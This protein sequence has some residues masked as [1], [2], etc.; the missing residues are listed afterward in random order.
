MSPVPTSLAEWLEYIERQHPKA[1]ALGLDRVARVR[2][3]LG[4]AP[5]FPIIT[6][7]GTNGKGSVCAMLEAILHC[8]GCRV[9]RYTSPH[10]L[11]YNERVRV[12][13]VDAR[14][15]ELA[16]GF[17]AVERA[18]RDVPLTYF[19]YGTLAGVR[20]FVERRV[21]VAVL[22]VGLG[23]RLDAVNVFDPDC[24]V[25]TTVDIDHVDYLGG[26]RES[27]G[28]E[29]AGI[30]RA[31]RPAVC[32]DPAPPSS[33]LQRAAEIGAQLMRID[34]DFGA[35]PQGRQ[36]QYWGPRGK[37]SALPYPALR[38][39]CQLANAAASIAVLDS[40][41]ERVPVTVNDIRAGLLQADIPGRFQVLPGR[42]SVI[43]DVAH[44]PQ[45]ARALAAS[46]AAMSGNGRIL[47]VFAMLRDKDI[48]GVVAAVKSQ[49][50]HW[51]IAGLGGARGAGITE[52]REALSARAVTVVTECRDVPAAYT[53]AC[54]IATENDRI[55]VFGSFYTVAAVMALR[56]R[57]RGV[58]GQR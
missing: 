26:D 6:V 41:R 23:G 29:K 42:P 31:G 4:L 38:G 30:F 9:G 54:D 34:V 11:R 58:P 40:M 48:S 22:E 12:A 17:A 15:E 39:T 32:A 55:L 7:G 49:V 16:E 52:L 1:I 18:R 57:Q 45:A 13:G 20:L 33:L 2:D 56:E 43:L 24:A 21:D 8:A 3:A 27:I 35:V 5:A 46:L 53:Q 14:D 51:F 36:W 44:N 10:L 47:A 28:R 25:V 37:R 19:E 50:A